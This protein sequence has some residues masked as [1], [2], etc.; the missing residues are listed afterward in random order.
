M[1]QD[2]ASVDLMTARWRSLGHLVLSYWLENVNSNYVAYFR[3]D[4]TANLRST[5][6][7]TQLPAGLLLSGYVMNNESILRGV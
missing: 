2:V 4:N 6:V 5:S 3:R 1:G 7:L